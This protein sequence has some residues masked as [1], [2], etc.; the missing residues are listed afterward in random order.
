MMA[1]GLGCYRTVEARK[2]SVCTNLK[3]SAVD[4]K[5]QSHLVSRNGTE[6]YH[7]PSPLH[8]VA[9]HSPIFSNGELAP[10]FLQGQGPPVNNTDSL[11]RAQTASGTKNHGYIDRLLL[12][13][14]SKIQSDYQR[15]PA[16]A[17]SVF[18]EVLLK[19]VSVVPP[20][21]AQAADSS[22]E[23]NQKELCVTPPSLERADLAKSSSRTVKAPEVPYRYSYPVATKEYSSDE[24]AAA[25]LRR[26][27]RHQGQHDSLARSV[28]ESPHGDNAES[29]P[30]ERAG[31]RRAPAAACS[32]STEESRVLEAQPGH[33]ASPQF[34][35]AKFV[36]AGSE[37]V[38]VRQA[39]RKTKAVKLRRRTSEKPKTVRQH[40]GSG[41]KAREVGGGGP[42]GEQR[43]PG[44][45]KAAQKP[46][47]FYTEERRHGSGSDSSH[48]SPGLVDTS[49]GFPRQNLVP[50]LTRSGKSRRLQ[51]GDSEH[52]VDPRRKRQAA[53]RWPS[54]VETVGAACPQR[55]VSRG[56]QAAGGPHMVRSASLKA[57][58]WLGPHQAFRSSVS[59]GSF[60]HHLNAR[61][62]PVPFHVSSLY[63]PRC[64]S[65]YSAECASLFHSTIAESSDGETSDNTTNRFGDSESSQSFQSLSDSDSSLSLDEEEQ[66]DSQGEDRGLVWA[67]G[68]LGPTAAGQPLQRV[69]RP[70]P[71][72]CRI[73]ASRA[74]KKKIR[75]FQPASLKV[76]TLV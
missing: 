2:P 49:R 6:V 44:K 42:K 52:P 75:R 35:H 45:G 36:P 15:R 71:A 54:D 16:E 64:E 1:Q 57:G 74:L 72:A 48:S 4:P 29:R 14:L 11:Q 38:K 61:Y 21:Q 20:L 17:A 7:Y 10:G 12:R 67:D 9:L 19:N 69:P 5:F 56:P 22:L 39:D 73:K 34:V 26:S 27:H 65:E 13:S 40:H 43:K 32:S 63:P 30:Q 37:R 68:A 33:A 24:V 66:V 31:P 28:S 70:E 51:S 41:Q 53:A 18:P 50:A 60:F 8:A 76:M 23:S 58:Q 47:P 46:P 62:P 25:S 3:T 59:S 55:H